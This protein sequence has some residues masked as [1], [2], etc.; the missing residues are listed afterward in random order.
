MSGHKDSFQ[1]RQARASAAQK[2]ALATFK[3][4]PKPD[5]PQVVAQR[6]ERTRLIALRKERQ[7]SNLQAKEA[8]SAARQQAA[9]AE[10]AAQASA[11]K[12]QAVAEAAAKPKEK[13]VL[14]EAEKKSAR[15]AR[16][17]ARKSR[18]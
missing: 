5:D 12:E 10:L 11:A 1:E 16:Y 13:A 17:A 14:S 9:E 7:A 4:Q 18:R 2:D 6:L 15:D 3:E 8:Q